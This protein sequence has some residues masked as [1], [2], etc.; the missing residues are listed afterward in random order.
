MVLLGRTFYGK[1][2]ADKYN[3]IHTHAHDSYLS[4]IDKQ[5]CDQ[6]VYMKEI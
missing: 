4:D 5:K 2:K 6:Q 3:F 1:Y